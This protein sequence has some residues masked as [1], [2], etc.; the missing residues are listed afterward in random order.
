MLAGVGVVMLTAGLRSPGP[1]PQPIQS[2][3]IRIVTHDPVPGPGSAVAPRIPRLVPLA[4]SRPVLLEIPRIG[5]RTRL[6]TAVYGPL[7]YP[8][9]R[10]ITYGGSFD[11]GRG[12]YRNNIIAFATLIG[13]TT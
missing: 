5:V 3:T 10:L 1:P 2:P 4:R 9:L 12:H 8:G 6:V 11:H 13:A 7:N